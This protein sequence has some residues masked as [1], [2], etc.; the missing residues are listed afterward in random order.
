M[1][2]IP[3]GPGGRTVVTGIGVLT[4]NG[5]GLEEFWQATLDG[6][7]GIGPL[8]RFDAS[9]YPARLAG[10]IRDFDP[11]RHLPARLLP[12]TDV[13]TRLALVASDWALQDAKVEPGAY[14]DYEMSVV[15]ANACGGFAFTHREFRKLWAEGPASVSVY[16][17][18]AWFYAVNTGQ[19]SI[20]NGLRGPSTAL[21]AEQA[22][23][24]DAIGHARRTVRAGTPMVVTGGVDSALDPWGWVSQL[25]DGRVSRAADPALAYLPFDERA[26]GHVPAEGGAILV[27]EDAGAARARGAHRVYGEIAGCAST[28]DP[29][30]APVSPP[31]SA[32]RERG[33]PH[34]GAK[35]PSGLG[36]AA[37]LALKDAGITPDQVD[38]VFADGAGVAAL[39][40]AEAEAITDVFGPDAVPVTVPKAL[41]GRM[42]SGAGP[43]DISA[44]LLSIRD[45]IIPP[46]CGVTRM[47]AEYRIDLVRGEARTAKVCCALVLGRG[48]HGFNSAVVVREASL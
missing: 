8:T 46:T 20:R 21:V 18:F 16:E 24:L 28:F 13:S 5:F 12:Q 30:P 47:P 37:R 42:Y 44:A 3:V 7:S 4:P 17:S 45:G 34:R 1:T 23:G 9:R 26:G 19:I 14:A 40:R 6:R 27:L 39:D 25:A 29:P 15:T 11:G 48:R 22:G 32:S 41:T 10:E 38:V 31:L 33:D 2:G 36:R 35:P 43:V